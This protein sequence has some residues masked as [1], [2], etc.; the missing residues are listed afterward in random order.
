[1]YIS[2]KMT[3][4]S[5]NPSLRGW[6]EPDLQHPPV[7]TRIQVIKSRIDQITVRH[8][9]TPRNSKANIR[10]G[11][12]HLSSGADWG[13]RATRIS[14]LKHSFWDT[15]AERQ[16]VEQRFMSLQSIWIQETFIFEM[17]SATLLPSD[18]SREYLIG[19]ESQCHVWNSKDN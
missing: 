16:T 19:S 15:N 2:L 9:I 17:I 8:L 12:H 3:R 7:R 14:A 1:M 6:R 5:C 18:G 11:W 13:N 10:L 4:S